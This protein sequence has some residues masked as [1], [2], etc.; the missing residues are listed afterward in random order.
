VQVDAELLGHLAGVDRVVGHRLEPLVLRPERDR[1]R[2]DARVH[3][4]RQH[5]HQAGVETTA[6]ERG[7]GDVGDHV[8]GDR[9]LDHGAQVGAWPGRRLGRDIGHP[10]V[11]LV[12]ATAVRPE[13]GP[14]AR[15][16]LLHAVDRAALLGQPVVEHRRDQ[17][18]GLG[19][20]LGSDRG[21]QRLQFGREDHAALAAEE[22]Q[23]L[24][25]ERVAGQ[26]H[27]A[28]VLVQHREREHAAEPLQRVRAP[29]P[30]GL[31]HHLGVAVG[32]EGDAGLGQLGPQFLVVVE[33][34]VV[35]DR[36][37]ALGER[38]VR[39]RRQVDDRQP[40]VRQVRAH[41]TVVER[42]HR[43]GVR[44]AVRD[45]VAHR[46]GEGEPVALLVAAGDAAHLRTPWPGRRRRRG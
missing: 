5:G 18:A 34:A 7:H 11:R 8:R 33:L 25:A 20:E 23:R 46:L 16:Q 12:P 27:A 44:T 26:V 32:S 15:R 37:A 36:Q 4:L 42:V 45:P 39:F 10:P 35:A 3:P 1:V 43:R 9:F 21:D 19:A 14:R 31:E 29:A 2:V 13:L 24:D 28:A 41:V 40:A 17:R 6:E 30:P 22:V 38:L